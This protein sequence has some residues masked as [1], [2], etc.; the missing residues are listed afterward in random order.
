MFLKK[1]FEKFLKIVPNFC[2]RRRA[3]WKVKTFITL[4][5]KQTQGDIFPY[6]SFTKKTE[7]L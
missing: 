1:R 5:D 6:F 4:W 3:K 2:L 7:A